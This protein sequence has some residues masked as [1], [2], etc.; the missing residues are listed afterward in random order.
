MISMLSAT[1]RYSRM[2]VLT[3]REGSYLGATER[4]IYP[5]WDVLDVQDVSMSCTSPHPHYRRRLGETST[6][7]GL[8]HVPPQYQMIA[9]LN[10]LRWSRPLCRVP[11]QL[12]V[13]FWKRNPWLF[14][15]SS[16]FSMPEPREFPSSPTGI[17]QNIITVSGNA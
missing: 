7:L 17:P 9:L 5:E 14:R 4:H 16:A 10:R 13:Y 2:N 1:L 15:P 3:A 12:N 8:A 6:K 11:S